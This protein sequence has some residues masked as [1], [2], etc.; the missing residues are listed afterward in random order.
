[1]PSISSVAFLPNMSL[2]SFKRPASEDKFSLAAAFQSL[3]AKGPRTIT[4]SAPMAV[5]NSTSACA[6]DEFVGAAHGHCW[7]CIVELQRSQQHHRRQDS[8]PRSY[9]SSKHSTYDSDET[10]N[11]GGPQSARPSSA[12]SM[13]STA[14]KKSVRFAEDIDIG[15]THAKDDYP[16][17]SMFAPDSEPETLVEVDKDTLAVLLQ[18]WRELY[19]TETN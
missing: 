17:R 6:H 5:D 19:Q 4:V 3:P 15:E 13:R 16:E 9:T 10:A 7:L 18:Q 1:M 14:S 2:K 8:L 11:N 12:L